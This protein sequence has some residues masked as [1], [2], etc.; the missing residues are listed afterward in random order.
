MPETDTA[1]ALL[2]LTVQS[3]KETRGLQLRQGE[4]KAS[5][6]AQDILILIIFIPKNGLSK[7]NTRGHASAEWGLIQVQVRRLQPDLLSPQ[8]AF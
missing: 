4:G 6:F 2:E 3:G 5:S 7:E 8:A 1:P